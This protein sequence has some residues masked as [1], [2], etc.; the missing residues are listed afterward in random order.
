MTGK[1]LGGPG[2]QKGLIMQELTETFDFQPISVEDV[3]FNYLPKKLDN[4]IESTPEVIDH[5]KVIN[6]RIIWFN[7]AG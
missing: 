2:S 3:V 7:C 1:I 5:L 4:S 6:L